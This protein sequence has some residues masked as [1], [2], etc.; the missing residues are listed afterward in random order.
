MKICDIC[1]KTEGKI[2]FTPQL[3]K[4]LCNK[5]YN[6]FR[7]HGKILKRTSRDPNEIILY[8]DYAEIILY[9]KHQEE[10]ARAI[11][12]LEDVVRVSKIKWCLSSDGYVI[13]TINHC[14]RIWLHRF[15]LSIESDNVVDHINHNRLDNRKSN[16]REC[17][18][19]QNGFNRQVAKNNTSGFTGIRLVPETGKWRA[20]I[21]VNGNFIHLKICETIEEAILI[22]SEAEEKYFGE[23][24]NIS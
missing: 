13:S 9:N 21:W 14:Q 4:H 2:R 11:V 6:Q 15:I 16:L 5:H 22:R 19:Q 24:K 3:E 20:Q 10:T 1:G 8:Y 18:T 23:F 12:D 17:T 7:K